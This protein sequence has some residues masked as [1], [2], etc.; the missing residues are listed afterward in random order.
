MNKE[1]PKV[2]V[3]GAGLS[4]SEA[5]WQAAQA[6]CQVILYEMRPQKQSAAH[7]THLCA[8]LVCSN[9]L[10]ADGLANAVGLLKEEMRRQHSLIMACAD[11]CRIP[12]GVALAV[13]REGFA[14][15]VTEKIQEHPG[16]EIRR[17]EVRE[18]PEEGIVVIAAGPLVSDALAAAIGEKTGD[19]LHF[20]DAVA[21]IVSGAS[22]D[23]SVA[24]R[25]SRYGR[26]ES[27]AGDYINCPM[28]KEEYFIFYR[29]LT[30]GELTPLRAFETEKDFEGCMPIE[31]MARRGV[32]TMRYGPLKPVGLIDPRTGKEPY[33]VVQL[34]QD[35]AASTM[36]NLVGFQTRLK[37]PEQQRIFRL[38]PGLA[39]GEFLRFGV[40][41]RNTYL[42]SPKLLSATLSLKRE[43]RI[44]FAGQITG[45]EGY[46][47]SAAA[48]LAAGINAARLAHD[49]TPLVWPFDTALGGLLRYITTPATNFQPMNVTFGLLP[50]LEKRIRDK[51]EKNLLI[52]ERALAAL[53]AFQANIE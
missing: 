3:I 4:G 16:I 41:H 21:P 8:E 20:H 5:A 49:K 40:M 29:A 26:G 19:F 7:H 12:A 39:Q 43:E 38:I 32:D 46:I 23:M 51:R 37:W 27:E 36:Y 30:E 35:D 34:R 33:A 6:G 42:Q 47:E 1:G 25:A 11:S 44:L 15:C 18:I 10:R 50:P 48:G 52:S 53:A 45:V 28:N 13:D 14:R 24:F 9:S 31:A 22:L 17:Q 2:T